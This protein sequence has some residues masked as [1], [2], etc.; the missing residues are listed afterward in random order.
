MHLSTSG[1]SDG[2]QQQT[3]AV[4]TTQ[5]AGATGAGGVLSSDSSQDG[6]EGEESL[7][8]AHFYTSNIESIKGGSSSRG[9]DEP[10]NTE[11]I[12]LKETSTFILFAMPSI[13]VSDEDAERVEQVKANNK[14]YQE[15]FFKY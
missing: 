9:D 10:T 11:E 6:V 5:A 15:V 1:G 8:S 12:N 14:K 2:Y 7:G 13:C 4:G 3:T